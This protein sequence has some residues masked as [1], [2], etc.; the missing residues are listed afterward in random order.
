VQEVHVVLEVLVTFRV[1]GTTMQRHSVNNMKDLNSDKCY[2]ENLRLGVIMLHVH[3]Y[4]ALFSSHC[5]TCN[6]WCY[7][8]LWLTW[9]GTLLTSMCSSTFKN[10]QIFVR[11][12]QEDGAVILA[13]APGV[14]SGGDPWTSVSKGF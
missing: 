4:P 2:C 12:S 1:L 11:L 13:G 5:A 3:M 10:D 8:I 7:L 6:E 9:T 14:F